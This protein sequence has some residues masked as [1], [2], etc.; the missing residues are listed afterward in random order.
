MCVTTDAND[1]APAQ[2]IVVMPFRAIGF[3]ARSHHADLQ[4]SIS[5][6]EFSHAASDELVA[7]DNRYSPQMVA[8]KNNNYILTNLTNRNTTGYKSL[9][10][11]V[12]NTTR[13]S[14]VKIILANFYRVYN[15]C[16]K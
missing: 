5:S 4:P 14:K 6:V 1:F 7:N 3:H 13:Q 11:F 9:S 16:T 2:P 8:K 15:I 12:N 10:P